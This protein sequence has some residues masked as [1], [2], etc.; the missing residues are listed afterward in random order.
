MRY[1][2][3]CLMKR[4]LCICIALVLLI[5]STTAVAHAA[6]SYLELDGFT[7]DINDQGE[8]TIHDYNGE[9]TD[10]TIPNK[11][12]RAPVVT[13]DA[14]A[15]FN[16]PITSLDLYKAT[17]L[18][19]IGSCAFSGCS[20]LEELSLPANV[21]LAFGSFQSCAELRALT[22]ADGIDTIPEQCFY[23]CPSLTQIMLPDSVTTIEIRAFGECTGLRYA[24]LSDNVTSIADNAFEN[25]SDLII[26]CEKDSYAAQYAKDHQIK[27][28]YPYR[29]ILGDADGDGQIT[30]LDVTFIQRVLA[31]VR[32]DP[33]HLIALRGTIAGEELSITDASLIQ[34]SLAQLA[35]AYPVGETVS[36]YTPAENV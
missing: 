34:R 10:V 28:E 24:Y 12:L 25:D 11:L 15:F 36:G 5:F 20:S 26:R 16:Q 17:G 7:F 31:R 27:A 14:Y 13:I 19:N 23:N 4:I 35:I 8:A 22:I 2:K 1:D 33:D 18:L 30:A 21:S 6:D 9:S 3:E 32:D 29:Y